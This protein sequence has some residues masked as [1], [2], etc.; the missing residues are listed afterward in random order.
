[1]IEFGFIAAGLSNILGVLICSLFF[2]NDVMMQTQPAVMSHFGLVS[3][4]L[5]GLAYVAVCKNYGQVNGLIGVFV[6]EKLCYVLAWLHFITTQSL[7]TV[8]G[9][10]IFA[11]IFYSIYG[12]NDFLFMLFFAYVFLKNKKIAVSADSNKIFHS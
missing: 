6:V 3:I 8:L 7:E 12:V 5:W 4:L 2:T 1:M 9:E 10:S 11:G